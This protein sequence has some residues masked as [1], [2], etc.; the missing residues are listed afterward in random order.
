MVGNAFTSPSAEDS[1]DVARAAVSL[2]AGIEPKVGRARP[3]A[4]RSLGS[5]DTGV[6]SLAL[7]LDAATHVVSHDERVGSR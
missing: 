3:L 1:Y 2:T 7:C 4:A 6:T 5:P